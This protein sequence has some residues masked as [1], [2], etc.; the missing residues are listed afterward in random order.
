MDY[1]FTMKEIEEKIIN[2]KSKLPDNVQL[3]V[4]TKMFPVEVINEAYLAG[5]RNFGENRPQEMVEKHSV[6]PNDILWHQIGSLQTNKVRSIIPFV[7]M[8]HSIDSAKLL[9]FVNKEA[10]RINRVVD[11]LMEVDIAQEDTKH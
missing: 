8:I 9:E 2:I 4:V 5:E 3:I 6:M 1:F 7:H 10:F 11:V